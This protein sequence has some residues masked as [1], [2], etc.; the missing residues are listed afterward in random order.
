MPSPEDRK[1]ALDKFKLPAAVAPYFAGISTFWRPVPEPTADDWLY[2]QSED[3]QTFN[4]YSF[5][6]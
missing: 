5:M 3:G 6:L 1:K 4:M 2:S